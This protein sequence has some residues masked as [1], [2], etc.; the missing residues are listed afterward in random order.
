MNA[1]EAQELS[2]KNL[3]GPVIAPF[4]QLLHR[5]IKEAAERGKYSITHPFAEVSLAH[6]PSPLE[7]SEVWK[8]LAEEGYQVAHHPDPD[9]GHPASRPYTEISWKP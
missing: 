5:K 1:K 9:P 7:A 8:A 6:F 4:M 3:K 2:D